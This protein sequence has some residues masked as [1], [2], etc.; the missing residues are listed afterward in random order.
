MFCLVEKSVE[1]ENDTQ[2]LYCE[3]LLRSL[4]KKKADSM[5]ALDG[6]FS[7]MGL[8]IAAGAMIATFGRVEGVNFVLVQ[9][10]IFVVLGAVLAYGVVAQYILRKSKK[11]LPENVRKLEKAIESYKKGKK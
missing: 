5:G 11:E 3:E 8:L 6:T 7:M 10:G 9:V 4:A 1:I 2:L